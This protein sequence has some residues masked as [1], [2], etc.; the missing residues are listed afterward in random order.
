MY[1]EFKDLSGFDWAAEYIEE[2]SEIGINV[3]NYSRKEGT[4]LSDIKFIAVWNDNVTCKT[5]DSL[6]YVGK[7]IE[8]MG[9]V[10][11]ADNQ[12]EALIKRLIQDTIPKGY[13]I[14]VKAQ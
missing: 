3:S 4:T 14:K 10:E 9:V 5:R 12:S 1:A 7:K 2:Y 13:D 8:N 6:D 11:M